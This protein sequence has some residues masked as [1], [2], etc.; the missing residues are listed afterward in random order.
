MLKAL[1]RVK[2][3]KREITADKVDLMLAE[4]AEKPFT[5]DGLA[6]RA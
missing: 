4:V 6:V 2:A 3:L 5:R 1:E